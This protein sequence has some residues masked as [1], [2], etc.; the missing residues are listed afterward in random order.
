MR[1]Y[2]SSYCIS[3]QE[4]HLWS[5]CGTVT[6]KPA[7]CQCSSVEFMPVRVLHSDELLPGQG[8]LN[9]LL[10]C[11]Q[12]A[13]TQSWKLLLNLERLWAVYGLCKIFTVVIS[14]YST[15]LRESL[16]FNSGIGR[17]E[18]H[19]WGTA[20]MAINFFLKKHNF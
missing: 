7:K 16:H 2:L 14:W 5:G 8:V 15:M 20:S 1:G 4:E 9:H 12:P 17:K 19:L 13:S 18:S 3:Y 11:G 6:V 10:Y